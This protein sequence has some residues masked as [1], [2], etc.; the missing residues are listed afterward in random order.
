MIRRFLLLKKMFSLLDQAKIGELWF[1]L[2]PDT[3]CPSDWYIVSVHMQLEKQLDPPHTCVLARFLIK[4]K[5]AQIPLC[6]QCM[7]ALNHAPPLPS[8]LSCGP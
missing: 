8:F 1:L 2:V 3:G 7:Y 6:C 4:I 5:V